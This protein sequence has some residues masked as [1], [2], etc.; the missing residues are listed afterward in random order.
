MELRRRIDEL[1]RRAT[2]RG[3][4]AGMPG[5]KR[6]TKSRQTERMGSRKQRA[7][8]FARQRM[9]PT[10]RVVHAAESCSEC[11]T[12]LAGGWVQQTS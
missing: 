3:P 6:N 11:G 12:S 5:N 2:T 10:R 1:E 9:E 4:S 8:G 7:H